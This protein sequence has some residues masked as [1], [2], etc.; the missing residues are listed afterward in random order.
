MKRIREAGVLLALVILS[1]VWA[2]TLP[3]FLS[4]ENLYNVTLGFS[5]VGIMAIGQAL[6]ML[7]G[8]IDL[9]VGAVMGLSGVMAAGALVSGV[10]M[11]LAVLIGLL[12]GLACGLV[13]GGLIVGTRIPPFIATLGMMSVARSLAYERTQIKL[14]SSFPESFLALGQGDLFQV[15]EFRLAVPV[16]ILISLT[17]LAILVLSRTVFGRN[18]YAV[19]GNEASSRLSGVSN[20]RVK[21][22][23]Y[24]ISGMLA[25]LAGILQASYLGAAEAQSGEGYELDVI[26]AVVIGGVSL[27]GGEGT[28]LGAVLGAALMGVLRNGLILRGE[29]AFRQILLIGLAIWIA[30]IVDVLRRREWKR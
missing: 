16:A 24:V 29:P 26:A 17:L 10:P 11:P 27:A 4:V 1:A 7:T 14:L 3:Q 15:G 23:A 21:L 12:T 2:V 9:S 18:L 13:S 5:F 30:A 28:A 6:V 8:G 19:G 25:G 22:G 20:H